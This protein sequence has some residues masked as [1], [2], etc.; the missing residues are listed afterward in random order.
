MNGTMPGYS[1]GRLR[2]CEALDLSRCQNGIQK[3]P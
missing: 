1:T 3:S 2:A